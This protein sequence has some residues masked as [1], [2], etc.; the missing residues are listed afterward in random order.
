MLPSAPPLQVAAVGVLLVF[1]R[2]L[3]VTVTEEE[4]VHPTLF[5]PVTV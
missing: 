3:T 1:A 2:S 5:D 4:A